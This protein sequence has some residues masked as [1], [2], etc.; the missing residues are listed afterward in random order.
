MSIYVLLLYVKTLLRKAPYV[1]LLISSVVMCL[2]IV[3]F[4]D[5]LAGFKGLLPSSYTFFFAYSALLI[6]IINT[7]VTYYYRGACNPAKLF[8][9]H[10]LP[11][12]RAARGSI[13]I[14]LMLLLMFLPWLSS[15]AFFAAILFP[16]SISIIVI[17]TLLSTTLVLL[18]DLTILKLLVLSATYLLIVLLLHLKIVMQQ[19]WYLALFPLIVFAVEKLVDVANRIPRVLNISVHGQH[20]QIMHPM[21]LVLIIALTQ[22]MGSA[23]FSCLPTSV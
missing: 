16:S 7:V 8:M 19:S 14:T 22:V 12:L 5:F 18:F 15:M 6:T 4:K 1:L 21:L 20:I 11:L 17:V 2:T 23:I 10:H 13:Y 3:Y 9:V